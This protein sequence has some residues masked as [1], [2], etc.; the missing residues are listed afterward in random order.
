MLGIG[1]TIQSDYAGNHPSGGLLV[2]V[3][4]MGAPLGAKL[5]AQQNGDCHRA[6]ETGLVAQG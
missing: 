3:R 1:K 5:F 2:L 6:S 4:G